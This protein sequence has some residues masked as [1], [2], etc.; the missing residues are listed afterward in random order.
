MFAEDLKRL[1]MSEKLQIMETLWEDMREKLEG[2]GIPEDF[3]K[4]L[5]ERRKR[6]TDGTVNLSEWDDIKDKIGKL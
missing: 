5:I 2:A 4:L 1:S 3:K 6:V